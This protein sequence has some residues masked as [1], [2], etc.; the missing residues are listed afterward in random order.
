MVFKH[1]VP[2]LLIPDQ[3]QEMQMILGHL[4]TSGSQEVIKDNYD[5]GRRTKPFAESGIMGASIR[6]KLQWILREYGGG[7]QNW[8]KT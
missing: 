6:I 5:P 3:G 7:G 4:E 1:H 2:G 8:E